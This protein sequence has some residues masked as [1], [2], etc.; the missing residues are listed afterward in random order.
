MKFVFFSTSVSLSLEV[1]SVDGILNV[2]ELGR[3]DENLDDVGVTKGALF[4]GRGV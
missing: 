4:R 2:G 3:K 1:P